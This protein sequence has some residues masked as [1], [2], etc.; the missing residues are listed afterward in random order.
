LVLPHR[1]FDANVVRR[2][3]FA[4]NAVFAT[5]GLVVALADIVFH[6]LKVQWSPIKAIL[7][8]GGS[9]MWVGINSWTAKE[10]QA[11][12]RRAL[13][14]GLPIFGLVLLQELLRWRGNSIK[15]AFSAVCLLALLS[16]WNELEA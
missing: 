13:S 9:V 16:V 15:I 6:F 7:S 11:G 14:V 1:S 12:R 10:L 5:I 3:L 4:A 2:F 8:I